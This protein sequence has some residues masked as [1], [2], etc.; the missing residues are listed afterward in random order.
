M[1]LKGT[2]A[3]QLP[4]GRSRSSDRERFAENFVYRQLPATVDVVAKE[5]VELFIWTGQRCRAI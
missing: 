4:Q 3:V 5:A 2:A 1:L